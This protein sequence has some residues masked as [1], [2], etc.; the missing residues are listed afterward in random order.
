MVHTLR[1]GFTVTKFRDLFVLHL[2]GILIDRKYSGILRLT[3]EQ[4][5]EVHLHQGTVTDVECDELPAADALR[6]ILW[7]HA[8]TFGLQAGPNAPNGL[9]YTDLVESLIQ[10][11]APPMPAS[12]LMM[13]NL[14]IERTTLKPVQQS[15]FRDTGFNILLNIKKGD[16]LP[17]AQQLM[18]AEEFWP[19][20]LHLASNGQVICSYGPVLGKLLQELQ[21]SLH[22]KLAKL[23]G[24]HISKTY[25]EKLTRRMH[26]AW[27]E[28]TPEAALDPLLDPLC[29][30]APYYDWAQ[31]LRDVIHEIGAPTITNRSYKKALA[32]LSPEQAAVFR[33]LL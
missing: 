3:L 14:F 5:A 19:G 24:A 10:K 12:C 32:E 9:H 31:C 25:E 4:N 20:L 2:I 29:G 27:P 7:Q 11:S 17:G 13:T 23:L 16:I 6:A 26:S 18:P 15:A 8:G 22:A 28:W 21:H 1:K 33:Q 30:A